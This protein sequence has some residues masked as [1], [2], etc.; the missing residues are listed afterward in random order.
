MVGG[1][2]TAINCQSPKRR[3]GFALQNG[4]TGR[5]LK[6]LTDFG[7]A[8]HPLARRCTINLNNELDKRRQEK[9]VKPRQPVSRQKNAAQ[10]EEI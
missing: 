7:A 8:L 9:R 2:Q 6:G 3:I 4:L 1:L 10:E 5:S